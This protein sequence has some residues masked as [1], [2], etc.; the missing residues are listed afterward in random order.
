M[1]PGG[2]D[3]EARGRARRR[4]SRRPA[5]KKRASRRRASRRRACS[6]RA[7][8][9]PWQWAG[10]PLG[11]TREPP[12]RKRATRSS[13]SV[14]CLVR[15]RE[16]RRWS[17]AA[18]PPSTPGARSA[19]ARSVC[20]RSLFCHHAWVVGHQFSRPGEGPGHSTVPDS[21]QVAPAR[22]DTPVARRA[23]PS[24]AS[25]VRSA[26]AAAAVPSPA[27]P[28]APPAATAPRRCPQAWPRRPAPTRRPPTWRLTPPPR[29]P[30]TPTPSRAPPA[31]RTR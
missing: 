3:L 4:A 17:A 30:R 8:C 29:S 24:S 7:L 19:E 14:S 31:P 12:A 16:T 1:Q 28:E 25:R 23:C 18:P 20:R 2:G 21:P 15:R 9:T 27:A 10:S 22:G 26:A 6:Q 5:R 13:L 11:G